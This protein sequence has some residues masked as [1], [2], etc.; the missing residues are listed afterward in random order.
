MIE[1]GRDQ[2]VLRSPLRIDAPV[3]LVQGSADTDVLPEVALRL[4]GH[5]GGDD[6]R[7]TLVKEADHRFSTPACLALIRAS[8]EEVVAGPEAPC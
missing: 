5:L 3:R 6:I 8:V 7:L 4:F 1:D 2:L